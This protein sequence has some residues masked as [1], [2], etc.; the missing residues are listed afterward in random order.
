MAE[1]APEELAEH[2]GRLL[3][4]KPIFVRV[5][6]VKERFNEQA[7]WEGT[8]SVFS[9]DHPEA[10]TCYAWSSSIEGSDRRRFYAVLGKP[11]IN[12]AADAVRASIVAD[13]KAGE[14]K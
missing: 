6:H 9:V 3:G 2:V 1:V 12:S 8:V 5:D 13:Y 10:D 7:V 11:P 4:V 14:G